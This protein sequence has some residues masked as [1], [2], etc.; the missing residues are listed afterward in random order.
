MNTPPADAGMSAPPAWRLWPY[1]AP[2]LGRGGLATLAMA[3][4]ALVLVVT[5][6]PLKFIMDSVLLH[7][8]VPS[9]LLAVLPA[10][11]TDRMLLLNV[12]AASMFVLGLADAW[13]NYMANRLFLSLAQRVMFAMRRDLFAHLLRLP[14]AFHR[15]QR[16][17]DIMTRMIDDIARVQDL[18]AG[19]GTG[20]LPHALTI[21][22]MVL[23]MFV[24]DWR[25][26]V[27]A[28]AI[29]P[30]LAG[31][32]HVWGRWQRRALRHM[33]ARD[34]DLWSMVQETLGVVAL[35]QACR[36]ETREDRRFAAVG[37]AGLQAGLA[38]IRIQ[39]P[40][41][42]LVNLI[43]ALST[44]VI[45]WYGAVQV[46][47]KALTAGDLLVFMAYLRGLV[48]PAR[49]MA[50][51]GSVFGRAV[52]AMGR[53]RDIFAVPPAVRDRPG[54]RAPAVCLGRLDYQGVAFGHVAG[55]PL[56]HDIS[57]SVEPGAMLALVG[58]SGAG[59]S[60]LASLAGRFADPSAGT[61]R[62]DGHDLR[63]LPLDFVRRNVMVMQ[64]E[65]L[66]L[67]G[68]VW[69]NIAYGRDGATRADAIEAARAVGVDSVLG[70]LAD[71]FDRMV[72]ER[73]SL[74]SGG[75]KQCIAIARAMLSEAPVV[76]LDEPSSNLDAL[77]EGRIVAAL[78]K[79]A[80][81]RACIVIAHRLVSVRSADRI[82]VLEAGRI[83]Q[84]GTHDELLAAGGLYARMWHSQN[85]EPAHANQPAEPAH[86]RQP[87]RA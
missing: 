6:W 51:S 21:G 27:L 40:F 37:G 80:A 87:A 50:K 63:D 22:G 71:G 84:A 81:T 44:G 45:I 32:T 26:A 43:I 56:L 74:L 12:M 64:Q 41:A 13:L 70:R 49:Q 30:L 65:S 31:L 72:G 86:T 73:G 77:T 83:A 39:A 60:T 34:G 76:V 82:L 19:V 78:R 28:V 9:W 48:T 2:H 52:V 36:A 47:H 59:K 14:L 75:Q 38:S 57:L 7:H 46:V 3:L 1:V 35:V 25:Y 61:V 16:G 20:L 5:P 85:A 53:L 33:R 11:Q 17:G 29:A 58:P 68:T 10:A 54:A 79:L 4:R 69:E 42:P 23:V 15:T 18:I 67:H 55:Q 66:L 62:L 8:H 24:V